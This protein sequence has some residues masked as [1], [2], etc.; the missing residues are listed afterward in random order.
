M[1]LEVS[2][3]AVAAVPAVLN[4][5]IDN[6]AEGRPR[7]NHAVPTLLDEGNKTDALAPISHAEICNTIVASAQAYGLPVSF[8]SNLIW[9]ESR[10][11]LHAVSPAGALGIA[12]FMPQTAAQMGLANPHNPL[13]AIPASAQL[14][15]QLVM[16]FGNLGL[17][18]A[19]YNAGPRRVADWLDRRR[20]MPSETRAYVR[21]I[22]GLPAEQWR[23]GKPTIDSFA[24]ASRLPC[25]RVAEFMMTVEATEE[26]PVAAAAAARLEKVERTTRSKSRKVRVA[27]A[28]KARAPR[29]AKPAL[30]A[31]EVS[32]KKPKAHSRKTAIVAE[33][34]MREPHAG[35][36][37]RRTKGSKT[38]KT[39]RTASR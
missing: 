19:A 13:E 15:H 38:R 20:T 6:I 5:P 12:Q 1:S 17:A 27:A 21:T 14:L 22:T 36:K 10:F 25:R 8:L 4:G 26:Q 7:P 34:A 28:S 2:R 33:K 29:L 11:D 9:Q 30:I 16:R 23:P 18:A 35:K 32:A 24:L 3:P 37:S 39:I 31:T